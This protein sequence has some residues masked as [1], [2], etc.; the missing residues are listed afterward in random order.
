MALVHWWIQ[1]QAVLIPI[2]SCMEIW[3]Y[4]RPCDE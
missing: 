2:P 3:V 1:V 4:V